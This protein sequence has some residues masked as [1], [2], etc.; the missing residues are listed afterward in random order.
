MSEPSSFSPQHTLTDKAPGRLEI[1]PIW[2]SAALNDYLEFPYV[3]RVLCI[4][5]HTKIIPTGKTR[6][7]TVYGVTPLGQQKTDPIRLLELARRHWSNENRLHWVRDVSFNEDRCRIRKGNGPQV[8]A[9]LRNLAI[10]L[11]RM[12]GAKRKSTSFALLCQDGA[13]CLTTP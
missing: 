3:G 5:P 4:D 11:L 2:A 1:R 10:S 12:A 8:M 6:H 7:K 13:A 9:S